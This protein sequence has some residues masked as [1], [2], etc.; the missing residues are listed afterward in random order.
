MAG[1]QPYL[2]FDGNCEEAVKYYTQTFGGEILFSVRYSEMP[3]HPEFKLAKDW[4]NKILHTVFK[5]RGV[6]VLA[7]DNHPGMPF[8]AGNNVHINVN[9]DKTTDPTPAFNKI[10]EG[11]KVNMPLQQTF[12]AIKY[13]QVTDRF[14]IC[15]MFNQAAEKT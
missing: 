12:W 1:I 10:A 2:I 6:E 13:G 11:G 5:I 14:G 8:I 4:E 7:S 9:Y 3:P 15:W